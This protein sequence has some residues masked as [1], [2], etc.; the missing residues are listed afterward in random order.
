M[1][2]SVELNMKKVVLR[3]QIAL[4]LSY[5]WCHVDATVLCFFLEMWCCGLDYSVLL[6]HVLVILTYLWKATNIDSYFFTTK[7][8]YSE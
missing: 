8:L 1:S 6:W 2:C 7:Y 5:S 3:G 4:L